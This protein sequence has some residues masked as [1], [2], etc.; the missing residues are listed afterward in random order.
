VTLPR[1]VVSREALNGR[2][3]VLTG[4]ELHHMRVRRLHAG[5]ALVLFDGA[6]HH[7]LGIITAID[8]RQAAIRFVDEDLAPSESPLRLV[9]AQAELKANKLDLVIEK[10]T[11]LGASELIVF[12]SARSLQA[13]TP[14]RAARWQRIAASGAKQ[15]QR[16]TVPGVRGPLPF[17]AVLRE[18]AAGV[19]L[20]FWEEAGADRLHALARTRPAC[21]S[22]LAVVG[23]EGGFTAD[24]AARAEAAGF[25]ISGL[26]R[27]VLRAETAAIV[28]L[29][30]CG[31]LWGDLGGSAR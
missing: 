15:C 25:A 19:R 31:F 3:T 13:T 24:E 26:G 7:R 4:T 29:T 27:R 18:P 21:D 8:R 5:S 12:T 9:L 10:A 28:A 20:L 23:P 1:F 2:A 14:A 16:S 22:V 17:E 6:G 11:E 30:L